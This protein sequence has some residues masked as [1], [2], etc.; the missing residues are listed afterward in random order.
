M[1]QPVGQ[2]N[3]VARFGGTETAQNGNIGAGAGRVEGPGL[4][5]VAK[6]L[7]CITAPLPGGGGVFT[8]TKVFL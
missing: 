8:V 5:E 3:K 6:C 4:A 7:L 2:V 1:A